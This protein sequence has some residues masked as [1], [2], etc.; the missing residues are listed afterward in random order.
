MLPIDKRHLYQA[1]TLV[2]KCVYNREKLPTAYAQYFILNTSVHSY[3][4]SSNNMLNL[5]SI[6]SYFGYRMVKFKASRTW[7]KLP[8]S[9]TGIVTCLAFKKNL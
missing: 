9:L 1:V 6:K 7:N 2:H 8:K 3:N 5:M 4:T